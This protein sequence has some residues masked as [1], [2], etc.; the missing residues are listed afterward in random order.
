MVSDELD[1]LMRKR[2]PNEML[3][4][5]RKHMLNGNN[6]ITN[7]D[8]AKV[9]NFWAANIER[10]AVKAAIAT[11]CAIFEVPLDKAYIGRIIDYQLSK[12]GVNG[13]QD[14]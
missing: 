11:L 3:Y 13:T 4:E 7:E 1:R 8:W 10:D 9:I 14:S 12:E 2:S 6:P 5:A